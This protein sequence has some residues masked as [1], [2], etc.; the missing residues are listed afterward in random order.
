MAE[1]LTKGLNLLL[2]PKFA[3]LAERIEHLERSVQ[4]MSVSLAEKEDKSEVDALREHFSSQVRQVDDIV[5][6]VKEKVS[7]L[8]ELRSREIRSLH[9]NVEQRATAVNLDAVREQLQ[10][11]SI[12]LA[13]KCDVAKMEHVSKQI[14]LLGDELAKKVSTSKV[15][16]LGK[17]LNTVSDMVTRKVDPAITDQIRESIKALN[18]DVAEKA[19]LGDVHLLSGKVQGLAEQCAQKAETSK[20]EHLFRQF[21]TLEQDVMRKADDAKT[22]NLRRSLDAVMDDLQNKAHNATVEQTMRHIHT[23]SEALSRKVEVEKHEQVH[24]QCRRLSEDLVAHKSQ[25]DRHGHTIEDLGRRVAA[26]GAKLKG[27][28]I[29]LGQGG[30]GGGM[31]PI[32]L[33][34]CG[35]RASGSL[36]PVTSASGSPLGQSML[37]PKV[38]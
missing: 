8:D 13:G 20:V 3:E 17:Q 27:L 22:E 21:E 38:T 24:E 19:P 33:A 26:D 25:L 9:A 11:V 14:D 37:L 36:P 18:C 29:T 10:Q 30:A 34:G 15:D 6:L 35:T 7:Q 12:T 5:G 2:H 32:S 23:L 4:A 16:Q 28:S 1:D 31:Q